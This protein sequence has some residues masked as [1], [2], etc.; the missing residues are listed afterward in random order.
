MSHPSPEPVRLKIK[1]KSSVTGQHTVR[2]IMFISWCG[3]GQC[4]I[5]VFLDQVNLS[6]CASV[7]RF[8][9]RNQSVRKKL[10]NSFHFFFLFLSTKIPGIFFLQI[11]VH[12]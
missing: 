8:N 12:V 1:K 4:D 9:G 2:T 3:C 10:T 5:K 6:N 11:N 7:M